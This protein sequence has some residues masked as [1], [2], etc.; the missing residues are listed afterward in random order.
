M[1]RIRVCILGLDFYLSSFY[2]CGAALFAADSFV[3][4]VLGDISGI[5]N[6]A[7]VK[8]RDIEA[9]SKSLLLRVCFCGLI[10]LRGINTLIW[11]HTDC[12]GEKRLHM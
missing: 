1:Q 12:T 4:K 2:R 7:L 9:D 8:H 5:F 10:S 6:S 11:R 3:I